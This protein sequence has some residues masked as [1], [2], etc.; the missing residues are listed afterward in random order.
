MAASIAFPPFFMIS[1][2]IADANGWAD[3]T[4]AFSDIMPFIGISWLRLTQE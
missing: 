2:P 1:T 3:E 4:I